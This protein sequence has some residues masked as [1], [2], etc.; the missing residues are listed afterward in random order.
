MSFEESRHAA[1]TIMRARRA[2]GS[3]AIAAFALV[4]STT[5]ACEESAPADPPDATAPHVSAEGGPAKEDVDARD[6]APP[7][8]PLCKLSGPPKS[9]PGDVLVFEDEFDGDAV[10]PMRWNVL[11]GYQGHGTIVSS[12]APESAVASGGAL[13][14]VTDRNPSDAEHPY[15][16]GHLDTLGELARTYGKIE[17]RARFPYAPGVWYAIW[18][19]PWSQPF[20]EIDIEITSP[21]KKTTSDVYFVN[22]WAAPPIPADERR[23]YALVDDIDVTAFHTYTILWK[24]GSLDYQIDGVTRM[25]ASP[26][27]VPDLPVYWII[28]GWVGGWVGMPIPTTPFPNTFEVDYVR[29][30]RV[31]GV[32]AEPAIKVLTQKAAH[33]KTEAIDVALANFD[34]ACAHVSMYDGDVLMKT[35]STRPYRFRLSA[36]T[37][38]KHTL[39]FVATDG[40]RRTTAAV[41]TDIE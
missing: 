9:T 5:T 17:F 26:R 6:A 15:V 23:S 14:I 34:E 41:V 30:Y 1:R 40:E 32:I 7:P 24:P 27:G 12:A 8:E 28:N 2:L 29:I 33:A 36:L 37:S 38:G 35:T 4:L 20:P 16:S 10:D 19:R 18:G 22:H 39:S 25:Q 3:T 31:D 11:S 13:R 21:T